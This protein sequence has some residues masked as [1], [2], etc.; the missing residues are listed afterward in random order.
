MA[1]KYMTANGME[2]LK[3]FGISGVDALINSRCSRLYCACGKIL[4]DESK[5][6]CGGTGPSITVSLGAGD[7]TIYRKVDELFCGDLPGVE[8]KPEDTRVHIYFNSLVA[9]VNMENGVLS[10]VSR[11]VPIMAFDNE[12]IEIYRTYNIRGVLVEDVVS[13]IKNEN[14]NHSKLANILNIAEIMEYKFFEDVAKYFGN[15]FTY[16]HSLLA[17]PEFVRKHTVCAQSVID[18]SSERISIVDEASLCKY[19]KVPYCFKDYMVDAY[20]PKAFNS[21]WSFTDITALDVYPEEIK[22]CFGYY[23]ETG[24]FARRNISAFMNTFD[25][26]FFDSLDKIKCFIKYL[27]KNFYMGDDAFKKAKQ[28]FEYAEENK[29][30]ITENIINAKYL[31]NMKNSARLT[32]TFKA[33]SM[34]DEFCMIRDTQGI[35]PAMNQVLTWLADKTE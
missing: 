9:N 5:C 23:I 17:N 30:P 6:S 35:V 29:L 13:L 33:E 32:Q 15:V 20:F 3:R 7:S 12:N 2:L 1:K 8:K 24:K 11:P 18:K 19:F 4:E 25:D 26:E 14:I 34:S 16:G 22:G 27:R 28:A 21:S 31:F 10:F